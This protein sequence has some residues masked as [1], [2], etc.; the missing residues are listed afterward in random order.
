MP[1]H[2]LLGTYTS[3]AHVLWQAL[4]DM[5]RPGEEAR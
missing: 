5:A 1:L 2:L 3:G 4:T